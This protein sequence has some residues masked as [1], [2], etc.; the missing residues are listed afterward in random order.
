[1]RFTAKTAIIAALAALA[2]IAQMSVATAQETVRLGNLKFAHYGAVSYVKEIAKDCGIVVEERIFPKGPD[3]MQA[4]LAGEIDVGA[5]ASEAA[6]SGRAA[7]APSSWSRA[8]RAAE[9][10]SSRARIAA[11]PGSPT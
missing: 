6:I 3:V 1:M 7:G 8:L 4:I 9:Q 11:S 10:G 2:P 5:T